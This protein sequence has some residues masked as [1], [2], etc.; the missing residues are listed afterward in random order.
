MSSKPSHGSY[1][2][3]IH[4]CGKPASLVDKHPNVHANHNSSRQLLRDNYHYKATSFALILCPRYQPNHVP[5]S[6]LCSHLSSHGPGSYE[7]PRAT[8]SN[9][10]LK[11]VVF[12]VAS[13]SNVR[14]VY[15]GTNVHH[16]MVDV[17]VVSFRY[18]RSKLHN[19][20]EHTFLYYLCTQKQ[21]IV[22]V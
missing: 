7:S 21:G 1:F 10:K 16:K 13:I 8:P 3:R 2:I 5:R 6:C 11:C 9:L 4:T 22:D 18:Y 19:S 14:V 20:D 17:G 12:A 15:S